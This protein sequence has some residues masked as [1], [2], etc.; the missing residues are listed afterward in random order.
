VFLILGKGQVSRWVV[1]KGISNPSDYE[2]ES[3]PA[4][5]KSWLSKTRIEAP[6]ADNLNE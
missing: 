5:W 3:I 1:Q 4:A 2:A 6:E